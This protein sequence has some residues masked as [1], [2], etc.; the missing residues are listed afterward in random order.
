MNSVKILKSSGEIYYDDNTNYWRA[1]ISFNVPNKEIIIYGT[2]RSLTDIERSNIIIE[3]LNK[4]YFGSYLDYENDIYLCKLKNRGMSKKEEQNEEDMS[5]S[6]L[7]EYVMELP[8]NDNANQMVKDIRNLFINMRIWVNESLRRK[9]EI[10]CTLPF[11]IFGEKRELKRF[12][13]IM[14]NITKEFEYYFFKMTNKE[15]KITCID[16]KIINGKP[17]VIFEIKEV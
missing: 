13:K 14:K 7:G 5:Y 8:Q 15:V 12:L 16:D 11:K 2:T 4:Y 6:I 9:E 10:C 3:I 17:T 1:D